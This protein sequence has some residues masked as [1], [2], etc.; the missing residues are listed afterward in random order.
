MSITAKCQWFV[1]TSSFIVCFPD[2]SLFFSMSLRTVLPFLLVFVQSPHEL[3]LVV[4][5]LPGH[6]VPA[7]DNLVA[8]HLQPVE[9]GP[10]GD[11]PLHSLLSLV[12]VLRLLAHLL[13][14][15]PHLVM[16]EAL[17]RHPPLAHTLSGNN[18]V[19][20][21]TVHFGK[22]LTSPDIS[23]YTFDVFLG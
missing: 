14:D 17:H 19:I 8:H 9:H 4:P 18:Q 23:K 20:D 10:G 6:V 11:A 7:G 13:G 1:H 12:V 5:L 22:L 16:V 15:G 2:T 21:C 3:L